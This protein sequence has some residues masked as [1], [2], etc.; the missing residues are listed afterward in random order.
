MTRLKSK[1]L[2]Y[3]IMTQI[4]PDQTAANSDEV[5]AKLFS[6]AD[7]DTETMQDFMESLTEGLTAVER[8]L[9]ILEREPN[10]EGVINS[11]FRALHNVKGSCKMCLIDPLA[12][13]SHAIEELLSVVRAKQLKLTPL[14]KEALLIALDF[15]KL[16]SE[17]MQ[18]TGQLETEQLYTVAKHFN[19]MKNMSAGEAEIEAATVIKLI[20]GAPLD[21]I[22]FVQHQHCA[23]DKPY[24]AYL[25]IEA[26]LEDIEFFKTLS[27]RIDKKSPFWE[28][29][30]E[31]ILQFCM[32]IN[33]HLEH[34]IDPQQLATAAYLHDIGMVFVSSELINK[35]NKL[36]PYEEQ[37]IQLHAQL[38]HQ[39]LSRMPGWED[40]AR[41]IH[42][43]HERPDGEGYPQQLKGD[44]ICRGAKLIA[45]AD[46]YFSITNSRADRTNK[47]S[48]MRA[49]AEINAYA[50]SQFDE[51]VVE[52]FNKMMKESYTRLPS[53]ENTTLPSNPNEDP[54]PTEH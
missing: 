21:G 17:F 35:H 20:G 39:L 29:R 28:N 41:I 25:K 13:Y 22:P 46:T 49:I 42:Q 43:H 2:D 27:L 24:S 48:M 14:L 40:A 45:V 6:V 30:T 54:S 7:L 31:S 3:L 10:N 5:E 16:R 44:Q 51:E 4:H 32:A 38:G 8:D 37:E 23:I 34:P 12:D 52:A 15:L 9:L 47:R 19:R 36:T 26:E 1:T 18:Q 11:L 53:D 50:G 33:N